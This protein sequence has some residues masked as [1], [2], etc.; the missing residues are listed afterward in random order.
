MAFGSIWMEPVFMGLSQS[1]A[2][3]A[4]M[5][6]DRN[7]AVQNLSYTLLRA[8][9]AA[10]GQALGDPVAGPPTSREDHIHSTLATNTAALLHPIHHLST[11]HFSF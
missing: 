5:A 4:G 2:I 1:A 7:I 3:A 9:L 6:I 8:A 10:A 11:R